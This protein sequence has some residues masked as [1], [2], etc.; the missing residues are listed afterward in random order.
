MPLLILLTVGR[1]LLRLRPSKG[2]EARQVR[3]APQ[4]RRDLAGPAGATGAKGDA[5]APGAQ[6]NPGTAGTPGADGKSVTGAPIAT[7]GVCGEATGVE[8]TLNA[9]STDVCSGEDGESGFTEFLPPEATETG[10][11]WFQG[12]GAE[13][14]GAPIS[15][16]I[17]LSPADAAGIKEAH[18]STEK[19]EDFEAEC[20]GTIMDPGAEPGAFCIW[21]S[22]P[23]FSNLLAPSEGVVYQP[24][25]EHSL[26]EA[27]LGTS[28]AIIPYESLSAEKHG[29]GSFAVTAPVAGP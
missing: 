7:G 1:R 23:P 5:G 17:P 15:F 13:S 12:N 22:G 2:R 9:T 21:I 16:S 18:F 20:P 26:E 27:G 25:Y 19:A 24:D 29:G 8:Y 6:G 4:D 28:G 11:W 10:T 14:Q 3:P